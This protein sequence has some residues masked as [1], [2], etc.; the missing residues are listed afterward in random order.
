MCF[1]TT[2][3]RSARCAK[4][5]IWGMPGDAI[6]LGDLVFPPRHWPTLTLTNVP[7]QVGLTIAKMDNYLIV[8]TPWLWVLQWPS[9]WCWFSAEV[10]VLDVED[11]R[12]ENGLFCHDRQLAF[13]P[14]HRGRWIEQTVSNRLLELQNNAFPH[15]NPPSLRSA[16]PR[17]TGA[18]LWGKRAHKQHVLRH[19]T[20]AGILCGSVHGRKVGKRGHNGVSGLDPLAVLHELQRRFHVSAHERLARK[21]WGDA[22]RVLFVSISSPMANWFWEGSCWGQGAWT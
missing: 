13:S 2:F 21:A 17:R 1:I 15:V 18:L 14:A 9:F 22:L 12:R 8:N 10:L 4:S 7:R 19:R 6:S 5:A 20:A 11:C 16:D 3:C